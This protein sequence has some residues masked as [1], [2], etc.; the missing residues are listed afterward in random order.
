MYNALKY[1][2]LRIWANHQTTKSNTQQKKN[3]EE[4]LKKEHKR[5]KVKRKQYKQ[6]KI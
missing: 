5:N 3:L 4:I 2:A 1:K 6:K